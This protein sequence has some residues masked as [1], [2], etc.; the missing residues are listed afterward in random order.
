MAMGNLVKVCGWY[1][2]EWGYS[3]RCV[4]LLERMAAPVRQPA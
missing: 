2:N 3:S 1:D 4:D